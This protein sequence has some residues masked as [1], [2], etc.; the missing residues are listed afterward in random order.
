M[1]KFVVKRDKMRIN[2]RQVKE[3]RLTIY[4]YIYYFDNDI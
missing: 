1:V 2:E 3:Q 4:I